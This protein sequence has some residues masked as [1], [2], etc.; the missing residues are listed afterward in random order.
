MSSRPIRE[1]IENQKVLSADTETTILEA[2][3]LMKQ[4]RIGA[5]MVCN[6]NRLVGMF[7]ERDALFRVMAEARDPQTTS[8]AEVMTPHPQTVEPD[9]P[10]GHALHMMYEGGFRHV[11]VVE[12]GTPV[13]LVSARH[14]LGPELREFEAQ[15]DE[16]EHIQ[17]ILA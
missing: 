9:K 4:N 12:N 14:A 16:R 11:P 6:K 3:R 13:G 8:L 7:T 2:S 17:E 1:I 5:L 10:L 15:M